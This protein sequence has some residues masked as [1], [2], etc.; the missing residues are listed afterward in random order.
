MKRRITCIFI[1]L[2]LVVFAAIA[3]LNAIRLPNKVKAFV[4]GEIE[5]ATGKKVF[6]QSMRFDI[7][8][9][10]VLDGLVLYDD[11]SVIIRAKEVDSGFLIPA[12]SFKKKVIIPVILIESPTILVE[13]RADNSF[14]ISELIPNGYKAKNG[15]TVDVYSIVIRHGVINFA[16]KT[17]LPPFTMKI[18][19]ADI[20]IRLSL[21]DKIIFDLKCVIPAEQPMEIKSS[22]EYL[23]SRKESAAQV[24]IK[25]II[26]KEFI[27]YYKASGFS[28]PKGVLDASIDLRIKESV[29]DADIDASAK[30][31]SVS[32]DKMTASLD[33]NVKAMIQYDA[34]KK[35]IEYAGNLYINSM[36]IAGI[37]TVGE[38]ENIKAKVEFNDSRLSSENIS[39]DIFGIPWK[40]KINLIN[41]ANPVFD[42]Y[43]NSKIRLSALQ[44]IL[45]DKFKIKFPA[46]IAGKSDVEF[47]LQ[48]EPDNPAKLNGSI[49]MRDAT[50]SLGSGNF[51]I[52][53]VSG[54][55][56]FTTNNLTWADLRLAYHGAGYKASGALTNF[57]SPGVQLDV[58]SKDITFRSI[59]AVE[60]KLIRL[61]Q[62]KGRYFNSEFSIAGELDLEDPDDVE[63]DIN[64]T[65]EF[66]L[67]DL[68]DIARTSIAISTMKPDGKLSVEFGLNGDIKDIKRC[69][70]AAKVKSD[71]ASLYGLELVGITFDYTQSEGAGYIKSMN[72]SFYGG[73]MSVTSKVDWIS[74]NLPYSV[75]INLKDANLEK[76]KKDTDMKDKDLAGDIKLYASINGS[77]ED[78]S[79]LAGIGKISIAKGRLW[80]LDL[81]RGLGGL[82]FTS[83]FSDI[84]FT[85]GSCN[86]KI[87]DKIFYTN[88]ISLKS[89]LL[90]LNG[91]GD[92][93]FDKSVNALLKS[94]LTEDAM[95]PGFRKN[96]ATAIGKFTYIE[97]SGTLKDPKYKM[98]PSVSDIVEGVANV[99]LQQ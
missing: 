86:F 79:T 78:V 38:L 50:I 22:G 90:N 39:V 18:E 44:K 32:K 72:S 63:A 82:I 59:F 91:S 56:Q 76:Y 29:V 19:D 8:K 9:G 74:K 37:D 16:D 58:T 12:V 33:S 73:S 7:L 53:H 26:P 88:D 27:D 17:L 2:L 93:G 55:M 80:Q 34:G 36:N 21:P 20:N 89:D 42:I 14:N 3:Y 61:A 65:L 1:I 99:F 41:F 13:R 24:T 35:E 85:E 68:K 25:N 81:F 94:E 87:R 96:I 52:E 66:E 60:D 47:A 40:A 10:L 49:Q 98:R 69:D 46:D 71:R 92:L 95:Y 67:K 77:F 11:T 45:T 84:V 6:L 15:I 28:F 64:G 54:K 43:A 57:A 83:D 23:I 30:G 70:I 62:L 51:P 31:L 5:Y 48:I 97:V 4:T 75:T